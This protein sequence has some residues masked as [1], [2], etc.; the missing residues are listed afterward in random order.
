MPRTSILFGSGANS[1]EKI[2]RA[3]TERDANLNLW[4]NYLIGACCLTSGSDRL[5]YYSDYEKALNKTDDNE[6]SSQA[7][8]SP[9]GLTRSA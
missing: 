3:T 9:G 2:R 4:K 7:W 1:L 5:L 8:S 6:Q